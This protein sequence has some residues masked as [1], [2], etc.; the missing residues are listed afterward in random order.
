MYFTRWAL[1]NHNV[2]WRGAEERTTGEVR[3]PQTTNLGTTDT[4]GEKTTIKTHMGSDNNDAYLLLDG[5]PG[6]EN[7]S[8]D[9]RA[10]V[11]LFPSWYVVDVGAHDSAVEKGVRRQFLGESDAIHVRHVNKDATRPFQVEGTRIGCLTEPYHPAD[12]EPRWQR[13]RRQ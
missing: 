6:A 5:Q 3:L 12:D 7:Y 10:P 13:W 4:S 9:A 1:P 11:V 8:V 2:K